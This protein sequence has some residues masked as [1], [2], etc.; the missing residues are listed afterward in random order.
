M[1]TVQLLSADS[2]HVFDFSERQIT[3]LEVERGL[4]FPHMTGNFS[5]YPDTC[6]LTLGSGSRAYDSFPTLLGGGQLFVKRDG[7][8]LHCWKIQR[9]TTDFSGACIV[10]AVSY[11]SDL[12]NVKIQPLH[13]DISP[14][15]LAAAKPAQIPVGITRI[16]ADV[17]QF[18]SALTEWKLAAHG[19]GFQSR[20][21]SLSGLQ[22]AVDKGAE[23]TE[24]VNPLTASYLA[25]HISGVTMPATFDAQRASFIVLSNPPAGFT[26]F[27]PFAAGE[28]VNFQAG[29]TGSYWPTFDPYI[30][31]S[32]GIGPGGTLPVINATFDGPQTADFL[33]NWCAA[34]TLSGLVSVWED[35][36]GPG[37]TQR[38]EIVDAT[39]SVGTIAVYT[40]RQFADA[41]L[42]DASPKAWAIFRNA[43]NNQTV[44][45]TGVATQPAAWYL[46]RVAEEVFEVGTDAA[47]Y[48]ERLH[49]RQ[50]FEP[51]RVT[52]KNVS[53]QTMPLMPARCFEVATNR[54]QLA[55]EVYMIVRMVGS[56]LT[57]RFE[58]TGVKIA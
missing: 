39:A 11:L 47:F 35:L 46:D 21:R 18:D 48:F 10:E 38:V 5:S 50:Q 19:T 16:R 15:T 12:K 30:F 2:V 23:G 27:A 37:L 45:Y 20:G 1:I 14:G 51:K 54:L 25:N 41:S 8:P 26:V 6:K 57:N 34:S 53:P 33:A 56:E 3:G 7:A 32:A 44:R 58:I 9:A 36:P 55:G 31:G 29:K 22:G 52:L 40:E 4:N 24:F 28:F 43:A 42:S 49:Q 13:T 17:S